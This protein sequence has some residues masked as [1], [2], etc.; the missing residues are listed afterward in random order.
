[1]C[2]FLSIKAAHRASGA[3]LVRTLLDTEVASVAHN[4]FNPRLP[5]EIVPLWTRVLQGSQLNPP[6]ISNSRIFLWVKC[7]A[8]LGMDGELQDK[9]M[10]LRPPCSSSP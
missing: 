4:D 1:M 9:R 5:H 8:S 3:G 6:R 2:L 7:R 10:L